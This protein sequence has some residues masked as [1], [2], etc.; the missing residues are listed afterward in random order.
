MKRT[1]TAVFGKV[2]EEPL[3][4]VNTTRT[5]RTPERKRH[6]QLQTHHHKKQKEKADTPKTHEK[7]LGA[8]VF[9]HSQKHIDGKDRDLSRCTDAA[10]A[11]QG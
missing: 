5:N 2:N 4:E 6:Q 10:V 11:A 3:V 9:S 1:T 7:K 8:G